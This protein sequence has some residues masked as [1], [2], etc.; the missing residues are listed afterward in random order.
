LGA[1]V[2]EDGTQKP[3]DRSTYEKPDDNVARPVS[4]QDNTGQHKPATDRPYRVALG[5]RKLR[6][7]GRK[8]SNMDGMT[9][10]KGIFRLSRK[11]NAAQMAADGQ[12]VRTFLVK[13]PFHDMGKCCGHGGSQE[14]M[15]GCAPLS[16]WLPARPEPPSASQNEQDMLVRAP[17]DYACNFFGGRIGAPRNCA[18]DQ[19]VRRSGFDGN[20]HANRGSSSTA[21]NAENERWFIQRK[22]TM[23]F[24]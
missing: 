11:R 4:K 13:D 9:G 15:V 19:E 20:G 3:L 14:N 12:A 1:S 7:S 17:R 5:G 10:W 2:T 18:R 6:C 22:K 21:Y 16:G 8:C 23:I 24:R